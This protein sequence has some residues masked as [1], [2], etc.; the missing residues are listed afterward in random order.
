MFFEG[1]IETMFQSLYRHFGLDTCT[2]PNAH[3]PGVLRECGASV[4]RKSAA[5]S[6]DN[7]AREKYT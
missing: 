6:T 7:Q 3:R 2:A 5:Y 1:R 4:R